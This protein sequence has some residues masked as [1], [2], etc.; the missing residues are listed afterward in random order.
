MSLSVSS[1]FDGGNIRLVAIDGDRVD[2]EIVKD[3][4]S[5]FYQWFYFRI[6]GG[7]GRELTLRLLNC[8]GSAYPHGWDDYRACLSLD[9]EEWVRI[10]TSYADGVIE[11]KVTPT[12]DSVWIAYFAPYTMERHHDLV[13]SV[14]ALPGVEYRS[15]G[16]TLDGQELDYFRLPGGKLQAWLYAR[17]HPGETMAEWWMEGAL[18]RLLDDADP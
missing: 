17:Q 8:A 7:A 2:L 15:L 16:Q 13:A 12:A 4:Q 5:D 18:E 10:D 11:M 14:A 1:A 3:H 6:T 9:R